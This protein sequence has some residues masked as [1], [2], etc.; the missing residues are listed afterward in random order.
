MIEN[1]VLLIY[2]WG[3]YEQVGK[4]VGAILFIV[5]VISAMVVVVFFLGEFNEDEEISKKVY[6][7]LT[8]T[9]IVWSVLV[10]LNTLTP[11]RNTTV[12]MV[13]APT[14][15]EVTRDIKDSNTTKRLVNIL[16]DSLRILEK[17]IKEN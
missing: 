4:V 9:A 6:K 16:D 17:K 11:S 3:I 5:P 15:I 2:L 1:P 8:R 10:G 12:M 7:V 14:I 13:S